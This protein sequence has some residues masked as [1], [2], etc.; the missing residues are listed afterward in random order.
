VPKLKLS[1]RKLCTAGRKLAVCGCGS[2]CCTALFP[3]DIT[4]ATTPRQFKT[5]W[6]VTASGKRS[7]SPV[8]PQTTPPAPSCVGGAFSG[9]Y[10]GV[11]VFNPLTLAAT[12][13]NNTAE[14]GSGPCY[15]DRIVQDQTL[16]AEIGNATGDLT[17]GGENSSFA[18]QLVRTS[19]PA[20]GG[21]WALQPS[22]SDINPEKG[23][24][25]R[26]DIAAGSLVVSG[27]YK[28]SN[29]ATIG[30]Q[31][32]LLNGVATLQ[33]FG[34]AFT[35][36]ILGP[37]FGSA[38]PFLVKE[39]NCILGA[40]ASFTFTLASSCIN[41][42]TFQSESLGPLVITGTVATAL[43]G[44]AVGCTAPGS[45]CASTTVPG[46]PGGGGGGAGTLEDQL[47]AALFS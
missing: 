28:E 13:A 30:I 14:L 31:V 41:G 15:V 4:P 39:G 20:S 33:A 23:I 11:N 17:I 6:N 21:G 40:G 47:D 8:N 18:S 2:A 10:S 7:V 1:G 34:Q 5:W 37:S 19:L 42:N 35:T 3:C 12:G 43:C 44:L 22:P 26:W 46:A 36:I 27:A 9:R 25:L 16:F 32:R 45:V 24:V 38:T 29:S